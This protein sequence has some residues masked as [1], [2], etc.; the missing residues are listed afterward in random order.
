M[1]NTYPE[2]FRVWFGPGLFYAVSD[3]KYYEILLPHC[4]RKGHLYSQAEPLFGKGLFT[5]PGNC[6]IDSFFSTS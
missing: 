4:L 3:P 2:I 1:F 5:A 6:E